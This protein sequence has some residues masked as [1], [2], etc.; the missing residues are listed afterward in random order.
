MDITGIFV[1]KVAGQGL[2]INPG[3][4]DGFLVGLHG[5]QGELTPRRASDPRKPGAT[6]S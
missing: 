2:D 1:D 5:L 4:A 6:I 3:K